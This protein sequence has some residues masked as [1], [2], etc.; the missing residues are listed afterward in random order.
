M[1]KLGLVVGRF[2]PFHGGH[3]FLIE[4][5][6]EENENIVIVIGSV[7]K[8]DLKKNPLHADE[9]YRR[10]NSFLKS[11][12][13]KN[14]EIRI[15]L[16][17]DIDSDRRWPAYLKENTGITDNTKN[18][19][20]TGDDNLSEEYLKSLKGL[21]FQIRTVKRNGFEYEDPAGIVHVLTSAT[22]IRNLHSSLNF[23][24]L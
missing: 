10:L 18:T 12:E 6:I 3:K 13:N 11:I 19:F 21:G 16:L 5:A 15:I 1:E 9:R 23:A 8:V 4:M 17:E 14:K 22:E 24:Q 7:G 20:Y 2:Q